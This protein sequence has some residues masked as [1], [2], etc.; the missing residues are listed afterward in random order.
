MLYEAACILFRLVPTMEK[1]LNAKLADCAMKIY[2]QQ[3]SEIRYA[4]TMRTI[5]MS[6]IFLCLIKDQTV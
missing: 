4:A 3:K 2:L 6:D 1:S 5:V